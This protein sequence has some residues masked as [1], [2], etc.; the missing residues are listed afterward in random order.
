[1][2]L[3]EGLYTVLLRLKPELAKALTGARDADISD[4]LLHGYQPKT[5]VY[6]WKFWPRAFCGAIHIDMAG[7]ESA[8]DGSILKQHCVLGNRCDRATWLHYASHMKRSCAYS[9]TQADAPPNSAPITEP[10]TVMAMRVCKPCA[11]GRACLDGVL[12]NASSDNEEVS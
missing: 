6:G 1:M 5:F 12:S 3:A 4:N 8:L 7:Q 9:A 11:N 2:L 10:Y